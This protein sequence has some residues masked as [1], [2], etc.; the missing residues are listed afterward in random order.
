MRANFASLAELCTQLQ[1][2][3]EILKKARIQEDVEELIA[4]QNARVTEHGRKA[5]ELAAHWQDEAERLARQVEELQGNVIHDE[6]RSL[7]SQI[8]ALQQAIIDRDVAEAEKAKAIVELQQR[9]KFL[10]RHARI[11]IT[12]EKCVGTDPVTIVSAAVHLPQARALIPEGADGSSLYIGGGR[13]T[14]YR[15][16]TGDA[17]FSLKHQQ[18]V[19]HG[20]GGFHG[21]SSLVRMEDDSDMQLASAGQYRPTAESVQGYRSTHAAGNN[22]AQVPAAAATRPLVGADGVPRQI[23][24]YS[25]SNHA[26]AAPL[27]CGPMH[28]P[29]RGSNNCTVKNAAT[30][31]QQQQQ[32]LG[33]GLDVVREEDEAVHQP[34]DV[35]VQYENPLASDSAPLPRE[36]ALEVCCCMNHYFRV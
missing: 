20:S 36:A 21:G 16:P 25:T 35:S 6:M 13:G 15:H 14:M 4:Q 29:G 31:I 28:A 5:S 3:N 18:T 17:S 2:E 34:V 32:H 23:Q 27:Q 26:N 19:A 30:Q 7:R 12:S 24:F 33:G 1:E 8:T 22:R 10:E 11:P 9:N